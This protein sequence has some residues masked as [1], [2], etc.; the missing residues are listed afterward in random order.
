V[1]RRIEINLSLA[2]CLS[3]A[4]HAFLFVAWIV[5]ASQGLSFFAP[6]ATGSETK[7]STPGRDIV[8][9]INEDDIATKTVTT[10]L[11][12][13]DSS[14]RGYITKEKGD[15]FIDNTNEF[16]SGKAGR[17]GQNGRGITQAQQSSAMTAS[18]LPGMKTPAA[19]SKAEDY[20]ISIELIH[21]NPLLTAAGGSAAVESEWTK[22]PSVK[23]MNQKNAIF[24]TNNGEF[25]F[26]TQKFKNFE[27]F[28]RMKSKIG[29]NWYPPD[30]GRAYLPRT[31][32][33][34]GGYAPGFTRTSLISSQEVYIY[35]TMD[36]SGEVVNIQLLSSGNN[37]HLVKTCRDE[38]QN[39]KNFGTVPDD[40]KGTLINIPFVFGYYVD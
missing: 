26:N 36:R 7:R 27:Y 19:D 11:S 34:N 8:V 33:R 23:G 37:P 1:E 38:I 10:L 3:L 22:I 15:T 13:R 16:A 29:R 31:M 28:K 35:F 6:S 2:I 21:D 20:P 12:E 17:S 4:L 5:P 30:Y 40:M 39:S 9:N 18:T 32:D 14:G 24:L 25:S